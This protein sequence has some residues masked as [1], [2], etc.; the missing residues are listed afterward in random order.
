MLTLRGETTGKYV[1]AVSGLIIGATLSEYEW[2]G[3]SGFLTIRK[4]GMFKDK[5]FGVPGTIDRDDY[6]ANI[7]FSMYPTFS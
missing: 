2:A 5:H 1:T 3:R 7:K 6:T 4:P